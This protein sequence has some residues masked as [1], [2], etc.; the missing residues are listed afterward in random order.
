MEAIMKIAREHHLCVVGRQCPGHWGW[1]Y[2]CRRQKGQRWYHFRHR[3][4]LIFPSRIW[5]ALRR[6]RRVVYPDDDLSAKITMIANHGQSVCQYYHDVVGVNSRLDSIRAAILDIKLKH[7]DAYA[8][9]K[10][11]GCQLLAMIPLLPSSHI[12]SRPIATNCSTHVFHQYTLRVTNGQ[13]DALKRV[14]SRYTRY[15]V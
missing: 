1:L 6:W 2:L 12:W 15:P 9:A 4:H 14:P 5:D 7:L 11:P 10:I 8:A 13:R 3:L